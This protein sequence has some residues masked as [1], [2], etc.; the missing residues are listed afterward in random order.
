[1]HQKRTVAILVAI[2][3][4]GAILS[5]TLALFGRPLFPAPSLEGNPSIT[6]SEDGTFSF[7]SLYNEQIPLFGEGLY[8]R[9]S[10]QLALQGLAQDAVTLFLAVPLLFFCLLKARKG[11]V[12]SRL[13]LAGTLGYFL[14]S[15]VSYVF[16]WMF[17]PLFLVYVAV[18]SASLWAFILTLSGISL[19]ELP[20]AFT[21]KLPLRFLAGVQIGLGTMLLMMWG[22]M[23]LTPVL[24]GAVPAG[25]E[26]YT[27]FVIQGMDLGFIVPAAFTGGVLLLRRRPVGYLLTAIILIKGGTLC[28][29]LTAMIALQAVNGVPMDPL[30]AV[31]F[32]FINAFVYGCLFLLLKNMQPA[33]RR[34]D[35]PQAA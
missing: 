1:M 23:V 3:L 20:G 17:N 16:L 31:G 27:T 35:A 4:L 30:V 34:D 26:H 25:L 24:T 21:A 12:R 2:V 18:M 10:R 28:T 32:L 7:R 6:R 29:S 15:Y 22:K 33:E 9:N 19:P 11:S 13:M 8:G 5:C 14:Y